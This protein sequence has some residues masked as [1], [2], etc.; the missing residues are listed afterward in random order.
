MFSKSCTYAL[1]AVIYLAANQKE[2]STKTNGKQLAEALEIPFH[3]LAKLLQQ[4]TKVQI[5]S[6]SKGL[7]GGFFLTEENYAKTLGDVV[8]VIDGN[9]VL[10]TCVLG[11][12]GCSDAHP[13][14]LHE[15]AKE[16][17][18]AL[19]SVMSDKSLTEIAD[20]V[21]KGEFKL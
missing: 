21:K 2:P 7:K 18:N 13:C 11:L 5:I 3:F 1:R 6:A 19:L 10:N 12:P 9:S 8:T 20:M 4:L 17:K 14:P 16:A 15:K